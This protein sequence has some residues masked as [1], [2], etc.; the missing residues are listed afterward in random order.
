MSTYESTS[1]SQRNR[2][3]MAVTGWPSYT[4]VPEHAPTEGTLHGDL[5]QM[6][7]RPLNGALYL[8]VLAVAAGIDIATFYQVLALV[9]KN[10][11]DEVVW[12]G[13]IGF[14]ATALA[15]A[16]TIG[17]RI[18]ERKDMGDRALGA[19][20]WLCGVVWLFVGI[21]AFVVRL[22]GTLPSGSNGTTIVEDGQAIAPAITG[23]D[24]PMLAALLFLALYTATG[25]LAGVAG[26]L[27]HNTSAKAYRTSLRTRASASKQAAQTMADVT[28]ARKIKIA[29]DEERQRREETW[30]KTQ[31]EW[32]A[33]ARRLKQEARLRLAAAAQDP[34]TTDA[35]FVPQV[36]TTHHDDDQVSAS[37]ATMPSNGSVLHDQF[38]YPPAASDELAT[39]DSMTDES[40]TRYEY[41]VPDDSGADSDD[42]ARYNDVTPQRTGISASHPPVP[43]MAAQSQPAFPSDR[44]GSTRGRQMAPI[45]HQQREVDWFQ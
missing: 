13:V 33:I 17:V 2:N 18:R 35:Y 44:S 21:T 37:P 42:V 14:T 34:T 32:A 6:T 19:S 20:V 30:V 11:P 10:V 23:A 16:H 25:T 43:A 39:D 31:E 8:G 36:R 4:V 9:M 1:D 5:S 38:I 28:L 12:L 24:S 7:Q 27:R 41:A 3:P 22:V 45:N 15:L 26:Y 29:L 40:A